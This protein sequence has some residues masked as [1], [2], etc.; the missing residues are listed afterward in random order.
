MGTYTELILKVELHKDLPPDVYMILEFLFNHDKSPFSWPIPDH[1]FF[2]TQRWENIGGGSSQYHVP[3]CLNYFKY[4]VLFSRCDL[5]N[6]DNEID[7]FLHWLDP[8]IDKFPGECIGW[9]WFEEDDEP[10][11]IYKKSYVCKRCLEKYEEE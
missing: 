9:K 3:E 10:K 4:N 6:Y 8:Y 5:K 1:S 2:K 7:M 11:L